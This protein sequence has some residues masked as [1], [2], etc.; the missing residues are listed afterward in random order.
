VD[1]DTVRAFVRELPDYEL[2]GGS[3]FTD[4]GA[5]LRRTVLLLDNLGRP[6][7]R[8][9]IAQ[10]AGTNGKGST[11]AMMTSVL[12]AAG[13]RT[14]LY[15]SPHLRRWEER[16]RI[17]D[18]TIDDPLLARAGALVIDAILQL[19]E[20]VTGLTRFE[21]WTALACVAFAEASCRAAVLEVGLGGRYDATTAAR[22]DLAVI[23]R[24]GLDHTSL[25]GTTRAAIA[26]EKAAIIGDRMPAVCAAQPEDA[27]EVI[28]AHADKRASPIL[29]GGRDFTAHRS[30]GELE[31]TVL[32][33]TYGPL[34][35]PL[36]GSFQDENA[37]TAVAAA[38]V[39]GALGIKVRP[40]MVAEGIARVRWPGRFEVVGD[41]ILDA[42]HNPDGAA[43]LAGALAA[44]FP[45]EPVTFVFGCHRDKDIRE[46]L[47][48]L[49]GR[50]DQLIAV[51]AR[52]PR[53]RSAEEVAAEASRA[54]FNVE[55]ATTVADGIRR[56]RDR[57]GIVVV[58][59]SLAVVGE[60]RAALGLAD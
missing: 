7:I 20:A 24:I 42:A 40:E 58:C 10:V 9:L 22:V 25:L 32:G 19:G 23:T 47:D 16:I 21:F 44:E 18:N 28:L 1:A 36:R 51:A 48:A 41:V 30:G 55:T 39:L 11:A 8:Y 35:L 17:S 59:G 5:G 26:S 50:S 13:A 34:A 53:A 49:H 6:D 38:L 3:P 33:T 52:N 29:V 56:G 2:T 45:E 15:T 31:V 37:A 14:G 54:R 57:G 4:A 27:L 12:E 60:A 46:M 43:A